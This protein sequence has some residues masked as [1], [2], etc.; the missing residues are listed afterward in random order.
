MKIVPYFI[1]Y[2]TFKL[3]K[4]IRIDKEAKNEKENIRYICKYAVD[5]R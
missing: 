5:R 2:Q 1:S 4:Q 3:D